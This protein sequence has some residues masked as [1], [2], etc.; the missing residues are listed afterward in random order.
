MYGTGSSPQKG[1]TQSITTTAAV[2]T[3]SE[4]SSGNLTGE[5]MKNVVEIKNTNS[6]KAMLGSIKD[7][8]LGGTN[9]A[10]NKEYSGSFGKNGVYN[11]KESKASKPTD[12]K[13]LVTIGENDYHSHPSGTEDF[14][15]NGES[16]VARWK[17]P[18]SKQDITVAGSKMQY[19]PAMRNQTIYIYNNKGVIATI[20]ISTFK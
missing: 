8:G 13:Q 20:P 18:P 19:V 5:H 16:Y 3:E 7:D 12:G 15:I 1:T 2:M 17:Q 9:L 11:T 6:M 14:T 10:N 4:I